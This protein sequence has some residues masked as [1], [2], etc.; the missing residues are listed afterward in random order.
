MKLP[1]AIELHHD[2]EERK[3]ERDRPRPPH[4]AQVAALRELYA[5]YGRNPF[6]PGDLVTMREAAPL[7][8]AGEPHIV[9]E[10][11]DAPAP[12]F[13]LKDHFGAR[14][15]VRVLCYSSTGCYFPIWVESWMIEPYAAKREETGNA[16]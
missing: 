15:D 8:G 1:F 16:A 4:E 5:A 7:H 6:K 14:Y 10:V 3:K 11:R 9:L 12:D 2:E 13:S